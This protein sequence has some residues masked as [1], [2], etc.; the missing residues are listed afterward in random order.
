MGGTRR[1][2]D[3][4]ASFV[5]VA[6]SSE[7]ASG[8]VVPNKLDGAVAL[9][10][11]HPLLEYS[12]LSKRI[13]YEIKYCNATPTPGHYHLGRACYVVILELLPSRKSLASPGYHWQEIVAVS[14]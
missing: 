4:A 3:A 8:V 14:Y 9:R 5:V 7:D 11:R 12:M 10:V 1:G 13:T 6:I 2:R